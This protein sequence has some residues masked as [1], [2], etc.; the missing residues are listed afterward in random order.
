MTLVIREPQADGLGRQPENGQRPIE[1][2]RERLDPDVAG[3]GERDIEGED[4]GRAEPPPDM[5]TQ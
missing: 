3:G 2:G 4:R 5:P 1:R